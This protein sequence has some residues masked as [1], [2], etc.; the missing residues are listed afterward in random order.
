MLSN[1]RYDRPRSMNHNELNIRDEELSSLGYPYA[2]LQDED[3]LPLALVAFGIGE[4]YDHTHSAYLGV[5]T[6]DADVAREQ[7]L[8]RAQ[9][10][11][12]YELGMRI[13]RALVEKGQEI[14]E[15]LPD[16][17]LEYYE[18]SLRQP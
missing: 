9:R 13:T 11:L 1:M 12:Y 3:M 17:L 15:V 4:S 8:A 7:Q 14:S 5:D 10:N 2:D 16:H 18:S 6:S